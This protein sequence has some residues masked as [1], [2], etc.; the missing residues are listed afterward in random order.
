MANYEFFS[1]SP[2]IYRAVRLEAFFPADYRRKIS[3]VFFICSAISLALFLIPAFL[4]I[5]FFGE[6]ARYFGFLNHLSSIKENILGAFLLFSGVFWFFWLLDFYFLASSRKEPFL[7]KKDDKENQVYFLDFGGARRAWYLS[8][9]E[10]EKI[11]IAKLYDFFGRSK[12]MAILPLRFGLDIGAFS[13]FIARRKISAPVILITQKDAVEKLLAEADISGSDTIGAKEFMMLLFHFDEVFK[14]FLFGLKIKDKELRGATA[15]VASFLEHQRQFARW[16]E[17][18]ALGRSPGIGKNLNFGFTYSLDKYSRDVSLSESSGVRIFAHQKEIFTIEEILSKSAE[19]NVLIVGEEGSGRRTILSGLARMIWEGR[20]MPALE[21]KR[22]V[23]LD[24]ASITAYAKSKSV[25]EEVLIKVM[26]EAVSAGNIILVI[27][28][29]PEFM[30]SVG[31]FGVDIPSLLEPYF[32]SSYI[33]AIAIS[34]PGLFHRKLETNG[35]IM[36]LFAKV[37]ILEPSKN[38]TVMILENAAEKLERIANVIVTYQALETIYDMADRFIAEGAMPEKAIDLLDRATSTFRGDSRF[39]FPE[40]IEKIIEETTKIPVSQASEAESKMLLN[41][42]GFLHKRIVGQDEAI[43]AVSSAV[44]R[45]RAGLHSGKRPIGSF[46]FLGPTGVGK[47][48]TAKALAEAYFGSE[49]N[50]LRFDM[51]EFQSEEGTQKLI[52]SYASNSQGTLATALRQTPF[53]VLLFDEFEKSSKAVINLFLQILD[54]GFFTDAFG[55]KVHARD[56]III[57]TSNAGSNLIWNLIKEGRDP[58]ALQKEVVDSIRKEGVFSPEILNRFDAIVVYH[59]LSKIQLEKIAELLLLELAGRLK[60][61]DINFIITKELID[62]V[63]EIGYDQVM[64]ARPM[65]RAIAD[66]VEEAISRK[67]LAG[68]LERGSI[69]EFTKDELIAL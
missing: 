2:K 31:T 27:D 68:Q 43:K 38:D 50:M 23:L 24:T 58:S 32:S 51:S 19:A 37:E 9:P 39:I 20:I 69:L 56:T 3:V 18:E 52:G 29:F 44:R 55:K 14:N 36:K 59:P 67:I 17:R 40:D 48:E 21:F 45:L 7:I 62:K 22:M 15:W 60:A 5:R 57:A 1:K 13:D 35:K 65:R 54:E 64:G 53:S 12:S 6:T 46:L 33:Q 25:L 61:K 16:W 63:A 4:T 66:R 42:E 34:S 8:L 10:S 30:E 41:L 47:T 11:D 26:N 28:N 49:K